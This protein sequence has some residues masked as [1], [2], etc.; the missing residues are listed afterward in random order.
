M[1]QGTTLVPSDE[2]DN[3]TIDSA[4][5]QIIDNNQETSAG[6]VQEGIAGGEEGDS[7]ADPVSS[8]ANSPSS[9]EEPQAWW[10]AWFTIDA[11][12]AQT[13]K[14]EGVLLKGKAQPDQVITI[15]LYSGELPLVFT[16]K[17][18]SQGSWE[19]RLPRD[20]KDGEHQLYLAVNDSFGQVVKKSGPFTL[21]VK[22]AQAATVKEFVTSET[23]KLPVMAVEPTT[24]KARINYIYAAI[25]SSLALL[26]LL[27][28]GMWWWHKRHI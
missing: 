16:T 23:E 18:D 25:F 13:A 6:D 8:P 1:P 14:Q 15:Y 5:E 7:S 19:Y 26:A 27:L 2:I 10:R 24:T 12:L 9:T 20:L 22:A 21:F 3:S 4:N 17:A 11:A 28:G